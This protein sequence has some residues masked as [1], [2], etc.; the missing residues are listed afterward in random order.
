MSSTDHQ[1]RFSY[2]DAAVPSPAILKTGFSISAQ[3]N[4]DIWA[5][6]P[7]TTR[8][9]APILH[10]TLPLQ[11]FRRARV[12]VSARWETLYD[13]GGL[14]LVIRDANTSTS[15]DSMKTDAKWVKTGIEFVNGRP[16]VSTVGRDKWADWSLLPVPSLSSSAAAGD[17]VGVTVEMAREGNSLWVYLL[18]SGGERVPIRKVTWAFEQDA[19][20]ECWIGA[21]A[22]R[23]NKEAG[24][25]LD[26]K[27]ANLEIEAVDK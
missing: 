22:A 1:Y 13:Q 11:Q 17:G 3:P 16:L 2:S 19:G 27:F 6:P 21:Y 8:F 25:A 24:G 5:K 18:D 14:V 9:N 7:S 12:D 23:P 4:T 26:V 15:A 20:K 10:R